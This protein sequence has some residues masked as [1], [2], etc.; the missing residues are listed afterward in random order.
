M[1]AHL[2]NT[3]LLVKVICQ[4]QGRISGLH[5]SKY[6]RFGGIGISKTHLVYYYYYFC[7]FCFKQVN[8]LNDTV[9]NIMDEIAQMQQEIKRFQEDE[10]K[11]E[12]NRKQMI[13]EMEVSK[14]CESCQDLLALNPCSVIHVV[15]LSSSLG[16]KH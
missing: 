9:E 10:V 4:G 6:G 11:S 8:E 16:F 1:T 3:H 7:L 15:G 5:F 14:S 13:R 12:E 2:I